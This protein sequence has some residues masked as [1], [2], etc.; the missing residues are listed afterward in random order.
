MELKLVHF[1]SKKKMVRNSH[2]PLNAVNFF[3]TLSNF[4]QGG[5]ARGGHSLEC[6]GGL[7]PDLCLRPPI[8][9]SH[10]L[11]DNLYVHCVAWSVPY[12]YVHYLHLLTYSVHV[13]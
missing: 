10:L 8:A 11:R 3:R 2:S 1:R 5:I 9:L 12:S 6:Q 7:M 13:L 4:V